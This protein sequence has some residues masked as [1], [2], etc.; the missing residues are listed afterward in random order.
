M[1]IDFGAALE[2]QSS[3]MAAGLPAV[4]DT[5]PVAKRLAVY[6]REL[7]FL[8]KRAQEVEVR[9]EGSLRLAVETAAAA[10]KLDGAIEKLRKQ[11]V[12]E[13]NRFIR[14]VNNLAKRYQ[15]RLKQVESGLKRKISEYQY[16]LELERRKAEAAAQE[17]ARKLQERLQA[18]AQAAGVEA[19]QVVAPVIPEKATTVR[20]AEGSAIQRTQWTFEVVDPALVPREYLT[21]DEKAIRAAVKAGV[22]EIPGVRIYEEFV[23]VIR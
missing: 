15:D 2:P 18:E 4:F 13:P 12:E 8:V 16:Q 20:T 10:K 17:E 11:Y 23:T 19:P 14:A 1:E 3:E 7:D 21:V 9:D 22:R 6:D 5:A